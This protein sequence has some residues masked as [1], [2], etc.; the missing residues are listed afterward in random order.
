M[1]D[2]QIKL[3]AL[4]VALMLTYLLGEQWD[5]LGDV[6]RIWNHSIWT[7][8]RYDSRPYLPQIQTPVLLINSDNDH[9]NT[10]QAMRYFD[11]HLLNSYGLKVV[12]GGKHFFQYREAEQV[13]DYMETFYRELATAWQEPVR[14]GENETTGAEACAGAANVAA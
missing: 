6:Q 13:I 4:W 9:V 5:T 3:S 14:L 11:E 8:A 7:M 10:V 1:A 12:R 2:V